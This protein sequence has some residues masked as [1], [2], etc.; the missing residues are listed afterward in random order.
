MTEEVH[1]TRRRPPAPPVYLLDVTVE[2]GERTR[3]HGVLWDGVLNASPR[4]TTDG[5]SPVEALLA[6]PGS[7]PPAAAARAAPTRRAPPR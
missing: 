6:A 7:A 2:P 4:D 5:P 3:A 1:V